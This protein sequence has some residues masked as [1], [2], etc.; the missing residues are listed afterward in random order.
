[1]ARRLLEQDEAHQRQNLVHRDAEMD[2]RRIQRIL[3]PPLPD[4]AGRPGAGDHEERG[5]GRRDQERHVQ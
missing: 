3:P 4:A 5:E 2:I 1:M